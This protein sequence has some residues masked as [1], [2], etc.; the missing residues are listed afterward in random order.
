MNEVRS[1][2]YRLIRPDGNLLWTCDVPSYMPAP[3]PPISTSTALGEGN[4]AV[5]PW[6]YEVREQDGTWTLLSERVRP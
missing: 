4:F 5:P 6:R 3:V 2:Q 1:V